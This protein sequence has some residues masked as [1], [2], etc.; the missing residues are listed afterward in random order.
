MG[1]EK[2]KDRKSSRRGPRDSDRPGMGRAMSMRQ[3]KSDGSDRGGGSSHRR[4]SSSQ[5]RN[6][7]RSQSYKQSSRSSGG[8]RRRS[9]SRSRRGDRSSGSGGGGGPPLTDPSRRTGL[10]R[11]V[12]D[13]SDSMA[14]LLGLAN[15]KKP[16][17]RSSSDSDSSGSS[18][19][20]L[21]SKGSAAKAP[22][23]KYNPTSSLARAGSS[24]ALDL[25]S[26]SGKNPKGTDSSFDT[27]AQ[28]LGTNDDASQSHLSVSRLAFPTSTPEKA[29]PPPAN[30]FVT[31]PDMREGV[32]Q[33]VNLMD[34]E[35]GSGR[36]KNPNALTKKKKGGLVDVWLDQQQT[37][38]STMAT[39]TSSLSVTGGTRQNSFVR[40]KKNPY[41]KVSAWENFTFFLKDSCRSVKDFFG[42]VIQS[43]ICVGIV[44]A[45][46]VVGIVLPVMFGGKRVK[47][48]SKL[49][50]PV[51]H[52]FHHDG[53]ATGGD[54]N[55]PLVPLKSRPVVVTI[56]HEGILYL[57][58][59]FTKAEA[60]Q[61]TKRLEQI[62]SEHRM[63]PKWT[64]SGD[65][66]ARAIE[67]MASYDPARLDM[68]ELD[69][70]DV[71]QRYAL[72]VFF[73]TTHPDTTANRTMITDAMVEDD[74]DSESR[75]DSE[76]IASVSSVL[77]EDS[78]TEGRSNPED[79]EDETPTRGQ[80]DE[81]RIDTFGANWMMEDNIC[82]WQGIQCADEPLPNVVVALNMSRSMLQGT[83]PPELA[84]LKELQH[85]D[86]GHND[87]AGNVPDVYVERMA[88][89]EALW[90]QDNLFTGMIPDAIGEWSQLT[91]LNLAQNKFSGNLPASMA[92]L[93]ELQ[94][95][96]LQENLL[97]GPVPSFG[98]ME[99]L[100]K[101]PTA[102][103]NLC[104]L[105]FVSM[106]TPYYSTVIFFLSCPPE[107]LYLNHNDFTGQIPEELFEIKALGTLG[108]NLE[109]SFCFPAS[110]LGDTLTRCSPLFAFLQWM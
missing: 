67:W 77:V 25:S 98:D 76:D 63:N 39:N 40:H 110:I 94:L 92:Q 41:L 54:Y 47:Q 68:D 3:L 91:C 30:T 104:F 43:R 99:Q 101:Y 9:R 85:M 103:Q 73:F 72:A 78:E 93:T 69:V 48:S 7:S 17:K 71:L 89:L 13:N 95:L 59:A 24:R 86:F 21:S 11:Q 87:L 23:Q 35:Q 49:L 16:R 26:H 31:R 90:L 4:R 12:S 19:S 58:P 109:S 64:G 15:K 45:V 10:E 14:M 22:P 44:L 52:D 100:G 53:D 80:Q 81:R 108:R 70:G 51:G 33:S 83:L 1:K 62:V 79:N 106:L 82:S 61:R 8:G 38:Q 102:S 2:D 28:A 42:S 107:Y 46:V 57:K 97:S 37:S 20:S 96:F 66:A 84:L 50:L 105:P 5:G 29:K 75:E 56:E 32:N 27:D 65:A 74:D 6:L 88:N 55:I 60:Q 34:L 18:N 36:K